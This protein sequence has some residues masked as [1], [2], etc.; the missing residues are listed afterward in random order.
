[1]A[2]VDYKEG[3]KDNRPWGTWEVKKVWISGEEAFCEK[4]ITVLP[5]RMLSI[6]SHD[7]RAESWEVVSGK[8]IVYL[9]PALDSLSRYEL[10]AGDSIEIPRGMIHAL[11]NLSGEVMELKEIQHGPMLREIDIVRY[12]APDGQPVDLEALAAQARGEADSVAA[13]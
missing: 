3:E 5:G 4:L 7:G 1:M 11:G 8:A 10:S 12:T 6:Q 13:A 9:G 2:V